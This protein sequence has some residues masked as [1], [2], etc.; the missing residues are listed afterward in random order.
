MSLSGW[1]PLQKMMLFTVPNRKLRFNVLHV[2]ACLLV[3]IF[4]TGS[5]H[6]GLPQLPDAFQC[7]DCKTVIDIQRSVGLAVTSGLH[8]PAS[9]RQVL[10]A[11]HVLRL[12][13]L[14]RFGNSRL[15]DSAGRRSVTARDDQEVRIAS[16]FLYAINPVKAN[17]PCLC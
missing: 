16:W 15:T 3:L 1:L 2:I 9:Y 10:S 5:I 4:L 7:I 17:L 11:S 14:A 12:I 13:T 8:I 6:T